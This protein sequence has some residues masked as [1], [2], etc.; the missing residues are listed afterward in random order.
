M[1]Q[2]GFSAPRIGSGVLFALVLS[3][4]ASGAP[5]GERRVVHIKP[6]V[7]AWKSVGSGYLGV[8]IVD[9]TPELRRHFGAPEDA[10]VLVARV[11][12][13]SPAEAAG[14]L[15][16]DVLTAVDRENVS[17]LRS[18]G[19]SIHGKE[20]GETVSVELRRAGSPLSLS[21]T[22]AERDRSV[23]DLADF[24]VELPELPE[25]AGEGVFIEGPGPL[26]DEEALRA[27]EESMR[28]I[29][30]RFES[31]EWQ[32]RL[33]RIRELDLTQVQERMREVE[34]RLKKL[35]K[36]LSESEAKKKLDQ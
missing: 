23:V 22:V 24:D 32:E 7:F 34:E 4:L 31:A 11:E 19:R 10:G 14:I 12:E 2:L 6:K 21:V 29:E 25:L 26:L 3:A 16:G 18:L 30:T 8:R 33:K 15:V 27:F 5:Q 36:E 9:L 1:R 28:E 13:D 20:S 35:E 17:D